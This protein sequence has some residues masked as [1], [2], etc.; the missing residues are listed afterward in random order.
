MTDADFD[1]DLY[2]NTR[3]GHM[4]GAACGLCRKAKVKVI[5]PRERG[6]DQ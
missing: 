4:T 6:T 5:N 2:N 1:K 3:K